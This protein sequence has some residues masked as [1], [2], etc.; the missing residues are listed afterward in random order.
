V[1][2]NLYLIE[3]LRYAVGRA[4]NARLLAPGFREAVERFASWG[5][6]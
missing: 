5:R 3:G 4:E 6:L 2:R 1:S